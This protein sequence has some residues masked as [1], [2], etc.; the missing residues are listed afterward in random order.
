[1]TKHDG[2]ALKYLNDTKW[3]LVE[4]QKEKLEFIIQSEALLQKHSLD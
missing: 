1:M 2:S 4:E 3:N